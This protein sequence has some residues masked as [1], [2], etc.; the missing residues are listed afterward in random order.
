[1]DSLGFEFMK[2]CPSS[3]EASKI[4]ARAGPSNVFKGFFQKIII[5]IVNR[6]VIELSL[7]MDPPAR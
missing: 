7:P 2:M 5:E 3:C 4:A 1:L 6:R